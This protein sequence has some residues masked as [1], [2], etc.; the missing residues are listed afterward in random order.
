MNKG[1]IKPFEGDLDDYTKLILSAA[2]AD[3][4]AAAAQ[5]K[6]AE[7]PAANGL[8]GDSPASQTTSTAQAG[9]EL[10]PQERR[11]AAADARAKVQPFK[12]KIQQIESK[13]QKLNEILS[14]IDTN[15]GDTSLYEKEPDK[16]QQLVM[17][18]G[19]AAKELEDAEADWIEATEALEQ[20]EAEAQA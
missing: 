8:D 15:L 18:R 4:K 17:E 6:G 13:M 5:A 16:A 1:T 14:L 10:T 11:R 2:R 12:K 20:A 9:P 3:R 7:V 19:K